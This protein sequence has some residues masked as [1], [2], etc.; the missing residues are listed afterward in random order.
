MDEERSS[1]YSSSAAEITSNNSR[2]RYQKTLSRFKRYISERYDSPCT[3]ILGFLC[4]TALGSILAFIFPSKDQQSTTSWDIVSNILGYTYFLSWTLSFYP[5]II[6]NYKHPSKA[7]HGLSLDFIVWNIIGFALYA[8]YTTSLRY[9]AVVRKEYAD[10]F[11]DGGNTTTTTMTTRGLILNYLAV[12][13]S[14]NADDG[15]GSNST[16]GAAAVPQVKTNDVAFAW[17]ALILTIITFIQIIYSERK[18]RRRQNDNDEFLYTMDWQC[19]TRRD[20]TSLGDDSFVLNEDDFH[21]Q[22]ANDN[23]HHYYQDQSLSSHNTTSFLHN[24]YD[25]LG[26]SEKYIHNKQWT[27][28]ISCTTKILICILIIT[29]IGF[30]ISIAIHAAQHQKQQQQQ[31]QQQ[32]L[33]L[34]DFLYFLSFVKVGITLIKYIP[35]VLLNYRRKS[36]S[37]WQIWNILLDFSGGTLSIIQLIGDSLSQ[38]GS[39]TG[40]IGN[41][42]KLGL[43]LVSISFDIIFMVQHYVLYRNPQIGNG[44]IVT[45]GSDHDHDTPLLAD[46]HNSLL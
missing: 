29:C 32:Q 5:Q 23:H 44:G 10:R 9:S 26:T 7:I 37:G 19:R 21:Q 2:T 3:I 30:G 40:V 8:V 31:Q 38:D 34:L 45:A 13:N 12:S 18:I 1:Q 35:Q 20:A 25:N 46:I 33:N 22:Q 43:G 6:T 41:P 4:I 24:S 27:K 14:T 16:H 42:A 39:W 17:H 28:R 15:G 11:G 36:T